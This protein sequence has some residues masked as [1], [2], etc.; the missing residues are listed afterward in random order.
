MQ[1]SGLK[2]NFFFLS[3][4]NKSHVVGTQSNSLKTV[5]LSVRTD[6]HEN[7]Y[8]LMFKLHLHV[9][10]WIIRVLSDEQNF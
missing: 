3:T 10:K 2:A 4:K 9:W 6:S 5:L 7:I 1:V 8:N